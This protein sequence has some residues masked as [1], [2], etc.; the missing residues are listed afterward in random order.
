M[1]K[2]IFLLLISFLFPATI[3]FSQGRTDRPY[4]TNEFSHWS[5]YLSGG[6]N[7]FVGDMEVDFSPLWD[8]PGKHLTFGGGVEYTMNP[9]Y[10][11]GLSYYYNEVA[12]SDAGGNFKS[13]IHHVYPYFGL[14]IVNFIH[15][16]SGSGWGFWVTA[17]AGYA[18]YNSK[19]H[20]TNKKDGNVVFSEDR[21]KNSTMVIPIGFLIEYNFTRNFAL[22]LR[23]Q[24][25]IYTTDNIEGGQKHYNTTVDGVRL[26]NYTYAGVSNDQ[27]SNLTLS[28]RWNFVTGPKQHV[29]TAKLWDNYVSYDDEIEDLANRV[30]ILEEYIPE[31]D[32]DKDGVPDDHDLEKDTP[33]NSVLVDVW[34]RTIHEG[35]DEPY[36]VYFAFDY[37]TLDKE[38]YLTLFEVAQILKENENLKVEII[39]YTDVVGTEQ[40]N[41]KLSERRAQTVKNELINSW[42]ISSSRISARGDGILYSP[43]KNYH[44]A[45][46]RCDIIIIR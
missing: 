23:F 40:Y 9:L 1:K 45:T 25:N 27:L 46:R 7:L 33:G 34:G 32:T 19:L 28:L 29:R 39:G 36:V 2:G 17:G 18:H 10:S 14:N 30:A 4:R 44:A 20:Y 35:Q 31:P 16:T 41:D 24:H 42:N 8:E 5:L 15:N 12:A 6:G 37:S 26:K 43:N 22:G 21:L 3:V 11:I 13:T 38:A